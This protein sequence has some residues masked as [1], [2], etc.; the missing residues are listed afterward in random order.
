MIDLAAFGFLGMRHAPGEL[1]AWD[2]FSTGLPASMGT[3]AATAALEDRIAQLVGCEAALF[4]PSTLHV[5]WDLV[6][7]LADDE[8]A[9]YQDQGAYEIGRWAVQSLAGLGVPVESF[10]HRRP[11]DLRG[12]ASRQFDG[13]RPIVVLDG[14]SQR[15]WGPNPLVDYLRV[16]EETRGLLIVDDTHALG[17]LGEPQANTPFGRGGGGSLRWHEAESDNVLY[18]ASLT[19]GFGVPIAILAGSGRLVDWFRVGSRT[20]RHCSPPSVPS[21]RAVE[22]ALDENDSHGEALRTQLADNIEQLRSTLN[23]AGIPGPRPLFPVQTVLLPPEAD[24]HR[25]AADLQNRGVNGLPVADDETPAMMF[26][27]TAA[28]DPAELQFAARAVVSTWGSFSPAPV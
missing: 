21:M 15:T 20:R 9:I 6:A 13:R 16:V 1:C 5:M 14:I 27:V 2:R 26:V 24:P 18:V 25:F 11:G 8:V 10:A 17:I 12:R 22:H 4:A 28:H 3:D 7:A 19:K 23:A